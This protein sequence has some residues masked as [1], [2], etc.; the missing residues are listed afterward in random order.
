MNYIVYLKTSRC[1][2]C[3]HTNIKYDYNKK[4]RYCSRCGLILQSLTPA[5][6]KQIEYITNKIKNI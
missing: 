6:R 1:P 4:E 3:F 5:T 2:E